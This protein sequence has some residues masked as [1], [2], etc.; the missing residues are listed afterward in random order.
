MSA[1]LNLYP[2]LVEGVFGGL[3]MAG[4]G[5][6]CILVVIGMISKMSQLLIISIVGLFILAY[7][8]GYVGALVA[9]PAFIFS[10][11]YFSIGLYNWV[12]ALR[13]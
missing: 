5:I 4:I 9:V 11:T 7:G 8:L 3:L 2:L 10:A 1:A 13:G 6:S 12:R